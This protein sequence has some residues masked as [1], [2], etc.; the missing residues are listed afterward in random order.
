M[1]NIFYSIISRYDI[2]MTQI[3]MP[4]FFEEL[5]TWFHEFYLK[6]TMSIFKFV[7][8]VQFCL[9]STR[10]KKHNMKFMKPYNGEQFQIILIILKD[11][12]SIF[13]TIFCTYSQSF[14][15]KKR[16]V[17]CTQTYAR[18]W[19]TGVHF[20]RTLPQKTTQHLRGFYFSNFHCLIF[21]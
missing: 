18:T 9:L 14:F 5:S 8:V 12:R 17:V 6:Q 4:R 7:Q 16:Y 1:K 10:L 13:Y 11:I 2:D 15:S 21:F 19:K 3:S 20:S